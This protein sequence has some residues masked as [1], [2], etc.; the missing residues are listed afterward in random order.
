MR[1]IM[2]A[3]AAAIA[4]SAATSSGVMAAPHG[5]PSGFARPDGF[6]HPGFGGP[7]FVGQRI[8]LYDYGGPCWVRR[9]VPPPFG[10]RWRLVNVCY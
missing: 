3:I 5:H 7:R 4:L 9:V 8:G 1:N 6:G 10:W 2:F